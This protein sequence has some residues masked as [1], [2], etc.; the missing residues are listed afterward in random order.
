MNLRMILFAVFSFV[1]IC[2]HGQRL[3]SFN[4]ENNPDKSVSIYANS[5]AYGEYTAKITFTTLSGFTSRSMISN[6]I[7]LLRVNRGVAEIMKFTRE[8][9]SFSNPSLQ[10]KSQYFPGRS[11]RKMPDTT[12]EYLLPASAGNMV[13]V[14]GVSSTVSQLSQKLINSEYRGTAFSYKL[15]DTICASRAGIVFVCSDTVMEG[16]KKETA[17]KSGRNRVEVQHRDGTLGNYGISAPIKLLVSPGD[18]IIPGQPLAV[19]NKESDKYRVY[20]STCYLDEAKLLAG[21]VF[22]NSLYYIYMPT[23]FYGN[24]GDRL[25][26]L[27]VAKDYTVQHPKEI[28]ASEMTK[29]EKKK[30]GY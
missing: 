28:I 15:Y 20:F 6:D 10:Y 2:S 22:D 19:F 4:T 27:Q 24:E 5:Q 3:I 11:F 25:S 21:T 26:I 7:A 12:Y 18:E 29:R 14:T 30:Y 23:R 17:F 13:R 8:N 16:E 1:G 9:N